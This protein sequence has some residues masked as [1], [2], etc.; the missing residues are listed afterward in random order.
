VTVGRGYTIVEGHGEKTAVLNL[1]N[2]LWSDLGLHALNWAD[3]IRATNLHKEE[4]LRKSCELVRSKPD[5]EVLLV[6]RDDEDGCPK[7]D[8]PRLA[9]WIEQFGLPFPT[10][11]VLAYREYETLFLPCIRAMAGKRFVGVNGLERVGLRAD[12]RYE[13]EF[14]SKRDVK[15][16][17]SAHME[18]GH[19]YK[20]TVDQLPLTRMVN[21][22]EV[23][24]SGLPW[25]GTLER[26]L[27]FLDQHRGQ[28]LVYPPPKA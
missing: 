20:P 1:L 3:P 24:A 4:L 2:R 18:P 27:R 9:G 10:A 25:F 26:A 19:S 12:A 21:F 11:V 6:L 7:G 13:G 14:E 23:R 8:G 22:E 15:G 28:S 5:I 16:W 17:L